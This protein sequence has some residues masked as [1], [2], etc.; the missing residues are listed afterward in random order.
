MSNKTVSVNNGLEFVRDGNR[1]LVQDIHIIN[2][3]TDLNQLIP[4][5]YNGEE[6]APW[7]RYL[8]SLHNTWHP[9]EIS[10][11]DD[12]QQYKGGA[13]T[14]AEEHLLRWNISYLASADSLVANNFILGVYE[15]ITAPEARQFYA[16]QIFE[17]AMHTH[18]YQHIIESLGLDDNGN[19]MFNG[20][21]EITTIA[22]KAEWN[23]SFTEALADKAVTPG[24][25][26]ANRLLLYD[27]VAYIVFESI[28]FWCAFSHIFAMARGGKLVNTA[29]QYQ[30]IMRDENQHYLHAVW[31]VN[32][33]KK[34]YPKLWDSHMQQRARGIISEAVDLETAYAHDCL[35]D[36]GVLGLSVQTY[37][38][39]VQYIANTR[40][41][42]LGLK[43]LYKVS[44]DP[45]PWMDD[46]V[47]IRKEKNFFEKRVTEYRTGGALRWD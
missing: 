28:Y 31:V 35:P 26:D 6:G 9:E 42:Q 41:I 8:D 10:M 4:F 11:Q 22:D 2:G 46:M 25:E 36:G 34:E 14:E 37:I 40:C 29:E 33:I 16:R 12:I 38:K 20:Y 43:P 1:P 7:Q 17:E 44:E 13:L 19:S 39:Y 30:Y 24:T 18:S 3:Q 15:H 45:L 27:L 21:R 32:Q 47:Y 5:K 23:M